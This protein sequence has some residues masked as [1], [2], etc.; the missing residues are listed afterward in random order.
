MQPF[1]TLN[2]HCVKT[3]SGGCVNQQLKT[4]W[5][6]FYRQ[7]QWNLTKLDPFKSDIFKDLD[8]SQ[9]IRMLIQL[10]QKVT[11]VTLTYFQN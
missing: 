6:D 1:I 7:I 9:L 4:F 5:D 11:D 3:Q 8:K 2:K 10:I